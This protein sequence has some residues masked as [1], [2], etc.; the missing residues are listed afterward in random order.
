MTSGV[1]ERFDTAWTI[2]P[3]GAG[4][5]VDYCVVVE[6]PAWVPMGLLHSRLTAAVSTLRREQGSLRGRLP[7][8]L[9]N[10]ALLFAATAFTVPWIEPWLDRIWP[11]VPMFVGQAATILLLDD[12][13]FFVRRWIHGEAAALTLRSNPYEARRFKAY[14]R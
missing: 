13:W 1:F 8:I 10:L 14:S 2:S 4:S 12:A 7:V 11:G 5:R 6:L 9:I 3:E